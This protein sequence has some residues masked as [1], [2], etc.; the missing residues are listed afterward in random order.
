MKQACLRENLGVSM[1]ESLS[2]RHSRA[3]ERDL[4]SGANGHGGPPAP[5]SC[6][7]RRPIPPRPTAPST[8]LPQLAP[9]S[10]KR[11]IWAVV[12]THIADPTFRPSFHPIKSGYCDGRFRYIGLCF[13]WFAVALTI[14]SRL[15][16]H[17]ALVTESFGGLD[18]SL[19][20]LRAYRRVNLLRRVAGVKPHRLITLF[21]PLDVDGV[22]WVNSHWQNAGFKVG[23]S[24]A[25]GAEDAGSLGAE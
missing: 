2:P 7:A 25:L 18:F 19:P 9:R 17:G 24:G 14:S 12:A 3:R 16:V 11:A 20:A 1:G 10:G 13:G 8:S 21:G 23:A 6:R 22:D 15:A 4:R 5:A